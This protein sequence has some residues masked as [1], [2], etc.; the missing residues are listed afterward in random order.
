METAL[1]SFCCGLPIY[2]STFIFHENSM[3]V[4]DSKEEPTKE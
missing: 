4:H 2:K 3:Q 1:L